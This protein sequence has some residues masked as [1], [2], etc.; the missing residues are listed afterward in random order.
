MTATP[1]PRQTTLDRTSGGWRT[2]ASVSTTTPG[3]DWEYAPAPES[4]EIV[5]IRREYGLFVAGE[6]VPPVSG[7]FFPTLNPASEETLATVRR[8]PLVSVQGGLMRCRRG[9]HRIVLTCTA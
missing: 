7:E 1:A 2:V 9:R 5:T 3:A 8:P 6:F 4:R